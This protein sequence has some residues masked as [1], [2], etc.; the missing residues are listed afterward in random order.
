MGLFSEIKNQVTGSAQVVGCS[1]APIENTQAPCTIQLFVQAPGVAPFSSEQTVDLWSGKWP[2]AGS[3]LAVTFDR[4]H[5]DRMRIEWDQQPVDV[6]ATAPAPATPAGQPL[7]HGMVIT[8][9][10]PMAVFGASSSASA[11]CAIAV[12]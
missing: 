5:T 11:P 4:D 1:S 10:K 12:H 6:T 2:T 9:G 8:T 3:T 7:P